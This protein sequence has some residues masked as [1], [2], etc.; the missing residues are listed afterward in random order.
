MHALVLVAVGS[1][2]GGAARWALSTWV[3]AHV[4]GGVRFWGTLA[5]NVLGGLLIG[6]CAALIERDAL[7]LL[8]ITG[9]LGG[10]TTFSAYSLQILQL[11]QAGRLLAAAAYALGSVLFCLIACWAG[12]SLARLVSQPGS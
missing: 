2:A 10:F 1:A 5:A 7:R 8:L 4:D 3:D 9:V 6:A 12:W 11:V